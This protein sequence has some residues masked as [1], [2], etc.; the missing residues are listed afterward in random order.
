MLR[1]GAQTRSSATYSHRAVGPYRSPRWPRLPEL[2][3]PPELVLV[4]E[5][6]LVPPPPQRPRPH[7]AHRN[8]VLHKNSQPLQ[9]LRAPAAQVVQPSPWRATLGC[10]GVCEQLM[11]LLVGGA[12]SATPHYFLVCPRHPH[13]LTH[14]SLHQPN[15]CRCQRLPRHQDRHPRPARVAMP[16]HVHRPI[17]VGLSHM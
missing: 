17:C 8:P 3:L 2:M 11:V 12:T 13:R 6:G 5:L 9:L 16:R 14:Q 1:T 15:S 10:S 7:R 4:P